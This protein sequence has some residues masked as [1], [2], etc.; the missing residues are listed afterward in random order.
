MHHRASAVDVASAPA[1]SFDASPWGGGCILWR[2]G[3]AVKYTHFIWA[4][5]TLKA[6]KAIIGD[7]RSQTAFEFTTLL[8]GAI[9]FTDVL[10]S[11]G[12]AIH[13]DNLGALNE[14]LK[15]RS[16]TPAINAISREL[17]WRKIVNKWRYGLQHLPAELNDEADALSRLRAEPAKPFPKEALAT[18]VFVQPPK[19][20]D[21]FWKACI[22]YD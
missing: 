11:T 19:Q 8:F 5:S 7:C 12:A 9:T 15:L 1:I 13:G 2:N 3:I 21:S 10:A 17:A 20:T 22:S 4:P 16:T 6:L 14:A 18:A